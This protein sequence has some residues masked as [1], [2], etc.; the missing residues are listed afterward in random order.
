MHLYSS[1][2]GLIWTR[3]VIS[4]ICSLKYT[5][6]VK[7]TCLNF[8]FQSKCFLCMELNFLTVHL[9]KKYV[10]KFS[11]LKPET[12]AINPL[13]AF[14]SVRGTM[15]LWKNARESGMA[16]HLLTLKGRHTHS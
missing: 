5:L 16:H 14:G 3:K 2:T 1:M 12:F 15:Q 9:R 7:K 8:P 6:E 13:G 10:T 11:Y 4:K